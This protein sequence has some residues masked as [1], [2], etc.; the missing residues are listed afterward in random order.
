MEKEQEIEKI[1]RLL[2]LMDVKA[3]HRLYITALNML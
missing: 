3:L 1:L 2:R